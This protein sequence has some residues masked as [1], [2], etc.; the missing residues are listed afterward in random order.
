MKLLKFKATWC[1]PCRTLSTI[2]D[3]FDACPMENIDIDMNVEMTH[4]Y[5]IRSVPTL[6]LVDAEG[7]E[8]WK[9]SGIIPRDMV[10]AEVLKYSQ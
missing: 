3:G 4:K 1:S 10:E 9:K 8:L 2:L 7:K 5:Q 6:V